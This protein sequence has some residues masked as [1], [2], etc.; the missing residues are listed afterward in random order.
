[1]L[2]ASFRSEIAAQK[3][4]WV[5]DENYIL[6]CVLGLDFLGDAKIAEPLKAKP[7]DWRAG[8]CETGLSGETCL[9]V[10]QG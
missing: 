7:A 2:H 8:R 4:F 6:R 5:F 9:R 1:M 3:L 10:W